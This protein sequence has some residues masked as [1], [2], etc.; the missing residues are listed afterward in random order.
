MANSF[1]TELKRRNVFKVGVAYLV[2]AWVVI[3]VTDSAVPALNMPEWMNTVVFF[4]GIIGFPFAI[5]FAWAFE[6]TPEGIKKESEIAPEDS[7]TSHTSRK[8][9]F[10]IIGLLVLVAGYFIY[11]S[12][13]Q[14]QSETLVTEKNSVE[15]DTSKKVSQAVE[16]S[17]IAVLPF[18][19]MSP[20]RDHDYF[21][22]GI[23]EEILNVLAKIP[24]LK[25]T[26]R[27]SAFAFKGSKIN[28]SEVAKK[29]GVNNVLE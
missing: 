12:R 23:S 1:F 19:D 27:S 5:F 21:S 8:L 4:L 16:G 11:E 13:F 20:N 22:D 26:S 3:Q 25:V 17:S 9:D 18:V 24:N 28:I 29:L 15:V 14:S 6:V 10:T 2:L 7:I